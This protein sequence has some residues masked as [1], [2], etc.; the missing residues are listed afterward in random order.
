MKTSKTRSS[1]A[2]VRWL[3]ALAVVALL[4]AACGSGNDDDDAGGV[5]TAPAPEATEAA[6]PSDSAGSGDADATEEPEPAE[7][8]DADEGSD[9]P[10][11]EETEEPEAAPDATPEATEEP[12]VLTDSFRGVTSESILIG[13]VA[14]DFETLNQ[15]FGLDLSYKGYTPTFHALVDWYNEQ[16]GVLGRRLEVVS[17]KFLPVGA[18]TAEAACLKLTE[19]VQVFAV[20]NG[21]AGPGTENVNT[22]FTVVHE[23]ILVGGLPSPEHAE[24]SKGL[25]VSTQM[26]LERRTAAF[27]SVLEQTGLIGEVSPVMVIGSNPELQGLVDFTAESL[28]AAGAEVP[29]AGVVTSTGDEYATQTEVDVFI[30][31]A[32]SQGVVSVLL[33]GE[34]SYRNDQLWRNAPEFVYLIGNGDR[35]SD[36]LREPPTTL[37]S[38]TRVLTTR[39]GPTPVDD[40]RIL[41]CIEVVEPAIGVEVKFP[42]ELE[43]GEDN[44]WAALLNTCRDLSMFIQIAEAAGPDLTNESWVAALD[45]TPDL[46]IPGTQFASVSSDKVDA[47]DALFLVEYDYANKEFVELAGPLDI[48]G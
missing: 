23:T 28:E 12:I 5:D 38:E 3:V 40:P 18:T 1:S 29:V 26:S 22:C 30:E 14:I 48:G 39:Q 8:P 32:R 13:F 36:W 21:F 34:G 43:E 46:S 17:E 20:I 27:A 31:R 24:A 44:Y 7:E 35:I 47:T 6:E 11:T 2:V 42:E 15:D 37:S 45:N 4:A 19:D 41:Q 16:G 25:W 9:A 33:L 10:A